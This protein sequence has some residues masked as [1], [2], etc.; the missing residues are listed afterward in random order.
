MC[1]CSHIS[2]LECVHKLRL[3]MCVF[4]YPLVHV[5]DHGTGVQ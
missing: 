2:A 4:V 1:N 3:C 5:G